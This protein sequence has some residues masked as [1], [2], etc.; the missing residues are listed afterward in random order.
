M[1]VALA[2]T[3]RPHGELPRFRRLYP[4]LREAYAALVIAVP[5]E[6]DPADLAA[7]RA[8]ETHDG[9]LVVVPPD[10]TQTRYAAMQKTL[11]TSATHIHYADM[12]R[13]LRWVETRPAGWRQTVE[14]VPGADC[15]IIGRS[16]AALATHPQALQLT[17]AIVN[18]VFSHLLGKAVDLCSGTKGF[19]RRAVEFIIAHSSPGHWA[20]AE[21]PMLLHRAGFKIDATFLDGLDWETADRHQAQAADAETQRRLADAYDRNPN[22]WAFRAQIAFDIVREGLDAATRPFET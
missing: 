11:E 5:A 15:L 1:S 4:Q 14:A 8:L 19:S 6:V 13:L 18:A 12:D 10:R 22:S 16:Q 9:V 21:W 20:D 7:V 2:C 17:E 3:W